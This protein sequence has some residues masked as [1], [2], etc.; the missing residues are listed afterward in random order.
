MKI[1]VEFTHPY[2]GHLEELIMEGPEMDP[3]ELKEMV[4]EAIEQEEG[5]ELPEGFDIKITEI[6]SGTIH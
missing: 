4:L 6:A 1:K 5:E 2:T 3:D